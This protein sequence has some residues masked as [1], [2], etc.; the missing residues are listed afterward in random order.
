MGNAV[1]QRRRKATAMNE[2]T[3]QAVAFLRNERIT[4]LPYNK[5]RAHRDG[6]GCPLS[7]WMLGVYCKSTSKILQVC[8][9][10]ARYPYST[11]GASR[12]VLCDRI[13]KRYGMTGTAIYLL[14]DYVATRYRGRNDRLSS[15]WLPKYRLD[16][17]LDATLAARAYYWIQ[18]CS[19]R[20]PI[21]LRAILS[22]Q[23][24]DLVLQ[25]SLYDTLGTINGR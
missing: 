14:D 1:T 8:N 21:P 16:A 3:K 13:S 10:N 9:G 18:D 5:R 24:T 7:A 17:P 15:K 4:E 20:Q 22:Q 11:L 2:L 23:L 12:S 6:N 19:E 25:F